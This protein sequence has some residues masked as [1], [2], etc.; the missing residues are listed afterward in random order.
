VSTYYC[1]PLCILQ[2]LLLLI[3][4]T[5]PHFLFRLLLLQQ[6]LQISQSGRSNGLPVLLLLLL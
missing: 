3:S 5:R 2:L 6:C 4:R 1:R